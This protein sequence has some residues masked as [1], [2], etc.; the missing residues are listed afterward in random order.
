MHEPRNQQ[1]CVCLG[2]PYHLK[3][4]N[5]KLPVAW[6]VKNNVTCGD[7]AVFYLTAPISAIVGYGVIISEPWYESQSDWQDKFFA[8]IDQIETFLEHNFIRIKYIRQLFPEWRYWLQPRQSVLT[9]ESIC[10]PFK[11]LLEKHSND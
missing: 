8:E 9:P 5:K 3:N 6:T 4:L 7:L 10:Q 11:E 1:I 2:A